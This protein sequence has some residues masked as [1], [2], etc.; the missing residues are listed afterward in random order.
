MWRSGHWFPF[1]S[2]NILDPWFRVFYL[3]KKKPQAG[4]SFFGG[5]MP[6]K[7]PI[8]GSHLP[9]IF[10][11]QIQPSLVLTWFSG[12]CLQKKNQAGGSFFGAFMPPIPRYFGRL[13]FWRSPA[14]WRWGLR[15]TYQVLL[16]GEYLPHLGRG[17]RSPGLPSVP[18]HS[19]CSRPGRASLS[20]RHW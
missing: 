1:W 5:F 17:H 11:C 20:R 4:G 15:A 2:F 6:P 12:P 7:P 14:P 3:K 10:Q 9:R 8:F 18:S 13:F 16:P 19:V